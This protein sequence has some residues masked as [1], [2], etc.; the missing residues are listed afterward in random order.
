MMRK[1][2]LASRF[3]CQDHEHFALLFRVP[4]L[5]VE[6]G[7]ST[8]QAID[9]RSNLLIFTREDEELHRLSTTIDHQIDHKGDDDECGVAIE[10]L[11]PNYY[12]ARTTKP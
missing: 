2:V 7:D 9:F 4:S 10:E 12:W 1:M 8:I 3:L 11:F 5:S 6:H